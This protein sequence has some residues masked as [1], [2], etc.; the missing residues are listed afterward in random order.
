M[1]LAAWVQGWVAPR[2]LR[3][4]GCVDGCWSRRSEELGLGWFGIVSV[5]LSDS[6]LLAVLA[7]YVVLVGIQARF[8]DFTLETMESFK[9]PCIDG[10]GNYR[11]LI[12]HAW[13]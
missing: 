1:P 9:V 4:E 2:L 3:H 12:S 11:N 10:A 8:G 5:V 6:M 13:P 7:I